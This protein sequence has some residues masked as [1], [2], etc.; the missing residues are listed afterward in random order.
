[1]WEI[2][3]AGAV[4][5]EGQVLLGGSARMPS[6]LAFSS[7]R[8]RTVTE[9]ASTSRPLE[10]PVASMTVFVAEPPWAG[11]ELMVSPVRLG[12][13]TLALADSV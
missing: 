12:G 8:P 5:L 4:A 11:S 7:V 9:F 3:A 6:R 13:T 2:P 1:M 10:P